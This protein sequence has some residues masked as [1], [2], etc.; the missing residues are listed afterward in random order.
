MR[1]RRRLCHRACCGHL[2]H[3]PRNGANLSESTLP[4]GSDKITLPR[5]K[6]RI[7]V[8]WNERSATT[9]GGQD[10]VGQGVPGSPKAGNRLAPNVVTSAIT[11]PP[12]RSTSSL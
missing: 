5:R 7:N 10:V 2:P 1:G 8:R 6:V 11:P 9:V 12:V 4:S 3:L